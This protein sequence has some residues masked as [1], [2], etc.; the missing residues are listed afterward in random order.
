MDHSTDKADWQEFV[1]PGFKVR[2]SY[3][4]VT[5]QGR[6]VDRVDEERNGAVRVHLTSRDSQELYLEVFYFPNLT[7]REEYLRHRPYLEQRF[8]ANSTPE[9]SE[10]SLG[11][12]PAW[13]YAFHWD[14]GER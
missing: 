6:V 5:Q 10:K 14:Q 13:A 3:P 8:G 11:Q 1:R 9:L 4:T 2:F 7:P 12:L